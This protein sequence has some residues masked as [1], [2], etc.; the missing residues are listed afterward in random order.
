MHI[1]PIVIELNLSWNIYIIIFYIIFG[2]IFI[3]LLLLI[4]IGYI[5]TVYSE[6]KSQGNFIIFILKILL[7]LYTTILYKPILFYLFSLSSCVK[8]SQNVLVHFYY[9][10]VI[11]WSG[12]HVIHS[13]FS[14][15]IIIIFLVICIL[16]TLT[17]FDSRLNFNNPCAK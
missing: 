10:D 11:C 15:V 9:P 12:S 6:K 1:L 17:L 8:D 14:F 4:Y 5:S 16:S 7:F 13:I 3:T 2:L